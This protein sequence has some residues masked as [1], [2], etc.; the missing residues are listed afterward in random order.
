MP[1]GGDNRLEKA[2]AVSLWLTDQWQISDALMVNLALRH[3]NVESSRLQFAVPD[4]SELDSTRSNDS[5][6]GCQGHHLLMM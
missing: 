4:R 5:S 2:E 3:E 1:T 6:G